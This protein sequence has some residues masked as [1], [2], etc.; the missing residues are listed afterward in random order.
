MFD[1]YINAEIMLRLLYEFATVSPVSMDSPYLG[2]GGHEQGDEGIRGPGVMDV[3]GCRRL[4]KVTYL[5]VY[6]IAFYAPD[7]LVAV[8]AL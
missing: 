4:Q 1:L 8:Y 6:Y 7:L 3:S 2:E 5:V